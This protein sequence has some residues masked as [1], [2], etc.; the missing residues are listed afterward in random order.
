MP[1][2]VRLGIVSL[3]ILALVCGVW[4][5]DYI[6]TPSPV[7][8]ETLV[9]IPKGAGVEHIKT[10]LAR[11]EL[12]RDDIRFLILARLTGRAGK[13]KAGEYLI[14]PR[15]RPLEILR[16]LEKGA[17]VSHRVT[18]PEGKTIDQTAELFARDRWID[19][20]R[21]SELAR[22]PQF[23]Q[24][25]GL[26]VE[27]LEGYLFPDTYSLVRGQGST[28]SVITMMVNRFQQVWK[29]VTQGLPPDLPAADA[30]TLASIVEKETASAAE[31]PL[32]AGVFLNRLKRGMRLQSDPTVI[33]GIRNFS[34]N[35]TRKDL[36]EDTPYNTYRIEGLP[37][38]PICSP[39]KAS[40]EAVLH[41]V[42][43]QYLYFVSRNDGTHQFSRTLRDHNRAV[44][45]F[46]K[47]KN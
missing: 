15:L 25:L 43:S 21:F 17:V 29:E 37:P 4:L 1:E 47:R 16:L 41:P 33:F 32:I 12:I 34:G 10:L 44:R 38:G 31:R 3:L 45:K 8:T 14:P 39:G 24:S 35:L 2:Q 9:Y 19:P 26:D 18:I 40:I 5:A 27:S 11:Q 28:E 7:A 42:E 6:R 36:L 23:I 22:N 46:Q 20:E 13:L 30:L